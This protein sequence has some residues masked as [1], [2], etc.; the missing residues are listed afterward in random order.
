MN[1]K[2]FFLLMITFPEVSSNFHFHQTCMSVDT[3]IGKIHMAQT[4]V[5]S[6]LER[7]YF[8]KVRV[9]GDEQKTSHCFHLQEAET[10]RT[11]PLNYHP[12]CSFLLD[13]C[14]FLV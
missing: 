7:I 10:P 5:H 8:K 4:A 6:K 2:R 13:L 14:H 1:F 9:V 12:I 3:K 11:L